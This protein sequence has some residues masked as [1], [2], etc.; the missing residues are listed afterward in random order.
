[1]T[2]SQCS[3]SHWNNSDVLHNRGDI[4]HHSIV[5]PQREATLMAC[6]A[7]KVSPHCHFPL[8][9]ASMKTEHSRGTG[10]DHQAEKGPWRWH[11][12]HER[13]QATQFHAKS[14]RALWAGKRIFSGNNAFLFSRLKN[15]K[16]AF[17]S[18]R[19]NKYPVAFKAFKQRHVLF[20]PG[21]KHPGCVYLQ[22]QDSVVP[23]AE[24][25][26]LICFKCRSIKE[27][28]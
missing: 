19:Q 17:L 23:E 2:S 6:C 28:F 11:V 5:S 18:L 8:L 22:L 15:K 26:C 21:T 12:W 4:L 14:V 3:A 1:M 27:G 10:W 9:L 25:H 16:D 13:Q 24:I 7:R 20:V